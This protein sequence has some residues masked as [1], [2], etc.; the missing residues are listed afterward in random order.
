MVV[1]L[2]ALFVALSGVAYGVA[3]IGTNDIKNGAVTSKKIRNNTIR[4]RDIRNNTIRS[5]DVRN[6]TLRGRDV[7]SETITANEIRDPEAYHE[8][9]TAGEIPF[10]N[11]ATNFGA[12]FSTAAYFKDNDGIVHLKG[13]V[14]ANNGTVAFTL[15][16]GYRPSQILDNGVIVSG[17][18]GYVYIRPNGDVEVHGPAGFGNYGLDPLS[19]RATG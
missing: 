6:H 16:P 17:T 15:P 14:R 19:F 7:H 18:I 11:G 9:G 1:A 4:T 12:G 10:Q 3:T 5:K 2:L 13:T 8:V